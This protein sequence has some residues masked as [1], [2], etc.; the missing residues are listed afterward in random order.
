MGA[1]WALALASYE[2]AGG[3]GGVGADTHACS[4]GPGRREPGAVTRQ[5]GHN[6]GGSAVVAAGGLCLVASL[7]EEPPRTKALWAARP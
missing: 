4:P 1:G 6:R 7:P 3:G 5:G 2:R